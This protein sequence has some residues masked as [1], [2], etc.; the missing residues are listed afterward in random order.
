M[1]TTFGTTGTFVLFDTA[2]NQ[3]LI[4]TVQ[5]FLGGNPDLLP[6]SSVSLQG[7]MV[8]D[9]PF[10]RGL[11]LEAKAWD[12]K[13]TDQVNTLTQYQ[14]FFTLYPERFRRAA[15]TAA[16]LA[17]GIP[18]VINYI[19]NSPVNISRRQLAGVDY[20]VMYDRNTLS[21]GRFTFRASA[22]T[23]TRNYSQL[24]AGLANVTTV[25]LANRPLRSTGSLTWRRG[26]VSATATHIW[27]DGYRV[28][29]TAGPD[30]PIYTQWNGSVSYD[31]GKTGLAARR[32]WVGRA[33][34][35]T[36][37]TMALVNAFEEG[38]ALSPTG[39]VNPMLDPRLRRYTL[40]FRKSL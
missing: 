19:D 2:R 9:V 12:T 23:Q 20:L 16:D 30:W 18:G 4:G 26:P 35:R 29:I 39:G 7:R 28:S 22:T 10:V 13:I 33:L 1:A 14:D 24:R 11:S 15:P 27:Q 31:F 21:W 36:R 25:G 5:R 40:T 3:Q 17:A 34:N 37:V 6:E 38:F 8:V 32:D